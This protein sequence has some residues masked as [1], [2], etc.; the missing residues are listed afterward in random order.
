MFLSMKE[1]KQEETPARDDAQAVAEIVAF[2]MRMTW[3][4]CAV[5]M[6]NSSTVTLAPFANNEQLV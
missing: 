5:M 3:P 4:V 1:R 2:V 6:T